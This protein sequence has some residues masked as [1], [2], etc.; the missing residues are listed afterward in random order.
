MINQKAPTAALN[1]GDIRAENS[2]R[3]L[4]QARDVHARRAFQNARINTSQT[5][6]VTEIGRFIV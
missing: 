3:T 6:R 1:I 5:L 4:F 2:I